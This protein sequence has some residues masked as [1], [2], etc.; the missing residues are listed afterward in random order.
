MKP[1]LSIRKYG[2]AP[3]KITLLHGGPGA[4]G[5]MM[6]VAIELS[7][8]F[9]ILEFLQTEHSVEG[10]IEEL[11]EQVINSV[12]H[13]LILI[14]YSW[15]AWLALLFAGNYPELTEKLI[16]ISAGAF[17]ARY[18]PDLMKIRLNRL[19]AAEKA[20]AENILASMGTP[21]MTA[22]TFA[23]FGE[24][25]EKAD[26]YSLIPQTEN[27]K[28]ELDETIFQKVWNEAEKLRDSGQLLQSVKKIKCPV[29]AIHGVCDPHPIAGVEIPLSGKL[30]D[31]TMITLDKCGHT[32]WREKYAAKEFYTTLKEVLK[33]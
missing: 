17:D 33:R 26:S 19:A 30:N 22:N 16:L 6:P 2:D 8:D 1:Q 20:E 10:Q 18:N 28:I 5:E 4:A 7:K 23:R 11:R 3:F 12:D 31:F 9:G 21:L 29:I 15:G 25:M 27:G 14:G 13:P 32:P 24:L